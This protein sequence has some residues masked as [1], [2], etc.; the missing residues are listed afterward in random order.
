MLALLRFVDPVYLRLLVAVARWERTRTPGAA[1]AM[2]RAFDRQLGGAWS[3]TATLDDFLGA[4]AL[5]F[6]MTAQYG[7]GRLTARCRWCGA[8]FEVPRVG[9]RYCVREHQQ[10]AGNEDPG[11]CGP[12]AGVRR[13]AA[14]GGGDG[15]ASLR[16]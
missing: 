6:T 1:R 7:R 10:R 9:A 13:Q 3:S 2:V 15:G 16:G 5:R 14:S 12:E 11:G 8:P 4:L